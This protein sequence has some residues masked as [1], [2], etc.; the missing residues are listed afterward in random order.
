M[1]RAPPAQRDLVWQWARR[2]VLRNLLAQLVSSM[3]ARPHKIIP[4]VCTTC[5]MLLTYLVIYLADF[6]R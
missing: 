6:L 1:A 3:A 4:Q 2:Q 5:P